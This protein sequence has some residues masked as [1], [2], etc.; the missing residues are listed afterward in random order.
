MGAAA[1]SSRT[2]AVI[3]GSLS[4][5][6]AAL[7]LR[8]HGWD[9]DLYEQSATGLAG[10]GAG[11]VTH[12]SVDAALQDL[13]LP[14]SQEFGVPLRGRRVLARDGS[15]IASAPFP[16]TATSWDRLFEL[17][18]ESFPAGRYHLGKKLES[19]ES[20]RGAVALTFA[21]R[22]G[23]EAHFV[24]GADGIRS[25]VRREVLPDIEPIYAGYV[26][27]RGLVEEGGFPPEHREGLFENLTFSLPPGEQM[28]GYPVAGRDNNLAPGHRR[29][30]FVWYRP[31][32][33]ESELKRLLTDAS[34]R[35][36][37]LSIPPPL[38]QKIAVAEMRAASERLLPALFV[39]AIRRTPMPFLQPIY[40]LAVP[41]MAF[42]RV[43]LI[44]DA[45]FVARPH[46]GAGVSKAAEDALALARNL[47]GTADI[48]EALRRFE[49]ERLPVGHKII[50]R[51]RHLGAYMQAQRSTP[52]EREP[53]ERHRSPE[54]VIVET[55]SVAFLDEA[56]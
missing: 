41:K 28:V 9:V 34:G 22:S 14:I 48:A 39:E 33:Q 43:A 23:S 13:G 54:A 36:H 40:D 50:A 29:F 21:D 30:N 16:Q 42:G 8:K 47:A 55:A 5:L 35:T 46:V 49:A 32:A 24:V 1:S 6:F 12:A 11:I 20:R 56:Y 19:I 17:L 44:G 4:G 27:W 2:A 31:A 26:A 53:A 10:R 37:E 25:A 52:E 51:A 7:L 45:A 18:R 3:G 15:L 38:I